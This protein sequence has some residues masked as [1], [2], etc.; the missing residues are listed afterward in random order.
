VEKRVD[1]PGPGD[2]RSDITGGE[3]LN[4]EHVELPGHEC[5]LYRR[6]GVN[7]YVL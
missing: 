2:Y 7:R 3:E 6:R 1:E 4:I 5:S